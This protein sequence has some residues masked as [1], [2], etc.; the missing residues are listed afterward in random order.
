MAAAIAIPLVACGG[1]RSPHA[2]GPAGGRRVAIV[3]LD[4]A[5]W[6][7]IDPLIAAG[8]LPAFA[9]LKSHGRTGVLVATPPLIS[10]IIWTT[11]ATGMQPEDHGVLDF[12]VD[13][14]GGRQAPVGSAQ[15]LAP[16]MWNLVSAGG[17]R[18]AV[19][20]WW[21]TWPAETVN[22]TI[23]S[24]ALAPQLLRARPPIAG[25][26]V[27]P[28]AA[29]PDINARRV[30]PSTLTR[31]DL[32]GYVPLTE[33]E[34]GAAQRAL[35]TDRPGVLY[36]DKL[37]HLAAVIAGTRTYST[38]ALDVWTR[39]RSG[40]LAVYLEAIDTVSHLFILD[41][42]R[43]PKAIEAAYR[44]A[45]RLISQLAQASPP[46]ALIVV[47]SDHGFH[48]PTAGIVE[49][50][51]D[52]AG[53]ATAWHRPYGIVAVATAGALT[54]RA[55]D[56]SRAIAAGAVE[57]VT[58]LDIAPTV[59]HAASQSLT[60]DM[61]GR[62][63]RDLLPPEASARQPARVA[64]PPYRPPAPAP[65]GDA[66]DAWAKLQALGYVG[67]NRTSLARR[68]LAESYFRRGKL[69]AAVRELGAVLETAPNDVT[70][71]LWLAKSLAG[72]HR[73]LEALSTY[74]RAMLAGAGPDALV[75][76]VDF[77]LSVGLPD[78]ARQL[79]KL[80]AARP[81]ASAALAIARGAVADAAGQKKMAE[82]QYR[83][84]LAVD[85]FSFE[86]L[87]RLLGLLGSSRVSELLPDLDRAV[88]RMPDSAR[89]QAL[90]GEARLAARNYRA[91][92]A[93][94]TRALELA[95]DGDAIRL[96]LARVHLMEQ[97]PAR[98]LAVLADARPSVDRSVLLGSAYSASDDW[99]NAVTHLQ[100]A[101]DDGRTTPDVLNGLGYA[102]LKLGQHQQAADL[103]RRSLQL[104]PG[105]PE[106]R[107]LLSGLRQESPRAAK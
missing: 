71:L 7:R 32:A 85:P 97:Q 12:M 87:A 19:V 1:N 23:V 77:A 53:P 21:A 76:A 65:G 82:H 47:V 62:V 57:T 29:E 28:P 56:L 39:E 72:L 60:R 11:I 15:R 27:S 73:T 52:L 31:E 88:A 37:A 45:D 4:A 105:Q 102:R 26:L 93:S 98:A 58:P 49:D 25:G 30:A 34:Y 81:G 2:G 70:A 8:R 43:G 5:D 38:I 63:I 55:V 46:D 94:L 41:D 9:R 79:M 42:A 80:A 14:G 90:L 75:E 74:D 17:R 3:A 95:P 48:A 50:P 6:S 103:F 92:E 67:G 101:L 89:H 24:D 18:V 64:P 99:S 13:L 84:A 22:G 104:N 78:R 35:A 20:G 100:S 106:I 61:P 83:A 44:D 33:Q 107:K 16:A 51:A 40:F 54:G 36:Q 69:D 68:H 91:A 59:L 66:N 96:S 10:P 86:A